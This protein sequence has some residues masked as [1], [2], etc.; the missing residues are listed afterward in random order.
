MPLILKALHAFAQ[1]GDEQKFTGAFDIVDSMA[2]YVPH[3]LNTN[4]KP[5][6]SC[7][8]HPSFF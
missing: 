1:K 2:E 4:V 3:L 8:M 7:S 5:S 6:I